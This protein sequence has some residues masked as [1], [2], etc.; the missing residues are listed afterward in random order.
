MKLSSHMA[1]VPRSKSFFSA[2]FHKLTETRLGKEE[3]V[4]ADHMLLIGRTL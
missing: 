4:A 3:Y 2:G 1:A